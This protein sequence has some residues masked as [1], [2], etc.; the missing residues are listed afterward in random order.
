MKRL[1]EEYDNYALSIS[2]TTRDPRPGEEDGVSLSYS[3]IRRFISVPFPAPEKPDTTVSIP[4]L[5]FRFPSLF[6]CF[7]AAVESTADRFRLQSRKDDK[8]FSGDEHCFR[9]SS[10]RRIDDAVAFLCTLHHTLD[11]RRLGT[12]HCYYFIRIY[13]I[14]ESDV[15]QFCHNPSF[16]VPSEVFF[17]KYI[18]PYRFI[19]IHSESL[20]KSFFLYYNEN[21]RI[22]NKGDIFYGF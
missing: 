17:R 3:S 21:T 10:L 4:L 22:S 14:A 11:G 5:I 13:D 1:M 15:D 19:I 12:H 7:P 8:F 16:P 9:A 6:F 20:V 18:Y 2:V